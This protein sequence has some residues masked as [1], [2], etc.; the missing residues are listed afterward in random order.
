MKRRLLRALGGTVLAVLLLGG[1]GYSR[2]IDWPAFDD[3]ALIRVYI[4]DEYPLDDAHHYT[5]RG[6]MDTWDLYRFSTS[7]E[8][9]LF[10]VAELKLES[11]GTVREFDLIISKPPAYWWDP[12]LLRE[13]EYYQSY[14]R[15]ADGR[16]YDLLYS[17]EEGIAYMIRFDG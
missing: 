6:F 8:A 12:E 4:P 5:L 10:L 13:A 3:S 1:V 9:I 14:E 2:Y 15:A 11:T 16:L 7:P 17:R